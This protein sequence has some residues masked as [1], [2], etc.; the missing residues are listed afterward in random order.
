MTAPARNPSAQPVAWASNLAI[1][2]VS[3]LAILAGNPVSLALG[4]AALD[5][6]EIAVL[7]RQESD[8]LS[9]ERIV[10]SFS[11]RA[12]G[13]LLILWSILVGRSRGLELAWGQALPLANSYLL[14]AAGLRLGVL[15]L[16][17]PFLQELP[18][19]RGLGTMLRLAPAIAS[20]TLVA[21]A[22]ETSVPRLWFPVLLGL[23]GLAALY[24]AVAWA[25]A[26]DELAGRPFWVLGVSAL[27]VMGA[28]RGQP[29]AS[30]AWGAALAL[31]GGMLFLSSARRRRSWFVLAGIAF[32]GLSGLPFTPAWPAQDV[33]TGAFSG[34]L[35]LPLLAQGILLAGF[36]RHAWSGE[37]PLETPEAWVQL[38]YPAGLGVALLSYVIIGWWPGLE[39][40][41]GTWW[42]VL[43]SLG[44][45]GGAWAVRRRGVNIPQSWLRSLAGLFSFGWLYRLFWGLY[46]ALSRLVGVF[47]RLLEGEGGVLWATLL[48]LVIVALF[49]QLAGGLNGF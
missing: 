40:A 35:I 43:V 16:H 11:V 6:V 14:L 22:A 7:L 19:R 15:P 36:V 48:L 5:M 46:R 45:L 23:A 27:A 44:L 9:R 8:S 24:G 38:V 32:L 47:S 30:V 4:L 41:R 31:P 13:N 1:A 34:W 29:Q 26:E 3:L 49:T 18:L 21:R 33:F 20:L 25:L 28:L 39:P 17:L 2:G 42:P 37:R 10:I 12:T